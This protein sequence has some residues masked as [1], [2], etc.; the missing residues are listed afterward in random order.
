MITDKQFEDA[1]TAAGGWFVAEYYEKVADW[2]GSVQ[3][4]IDDIFRHGH[5]DAKRTGTNTRVSSL[6]RIIEHGRSA[7]ALRRVVAS[8]RIAAQNPNA[9]RTARRILAERF[10]RL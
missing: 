6:L 5:T 3:D 1:F 2:K 9:V 7:E 4:L 10:S 8:S